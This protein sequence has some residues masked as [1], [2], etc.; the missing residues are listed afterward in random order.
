MYKVL[1]TVLR[2][3][4]EKTSFA[5]ERRTAFAFLLGTLV[6]QSVCLNLLG[7]KSF[8]ERERKLNIV[9]LVTENLIEVSFVS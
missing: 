5:V 6:L 4:K 7:W 9:H 1:L 3:L 8:T 2:L